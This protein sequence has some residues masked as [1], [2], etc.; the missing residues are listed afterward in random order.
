MPAPQPR[1]FW[2][3]QTWR[4]AR[5]RQS[6]ILAASRVT[7]TQVITKGDTIPRFVADPTITNIRSGS[8]SDPT[9]WSL[10]RVPINGDKVQIARGLPVTYST[11]SHASINGIEVDG[12]LIFS[13]TVNTQLIV[14]NLMVMPTGTLQIGT[15]SQ[16]VSPNVHAQLVIADQAVSDWLTIRRNTARA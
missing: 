9:I 6:R 3:V 15:A 1:L 8:W 5:R 2:P 4:R 13:T 14:G 16:P 10:G 12:S 11:V 7:P